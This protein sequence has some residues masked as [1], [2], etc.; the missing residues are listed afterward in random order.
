MPI[1]LREWKQKA[2]KCINEKFTTTGQGTLNHE[3]YLE[4]S[5]FE[6]LF[7]GSVERSLKRLTL[8]RME[9]VNGTKRF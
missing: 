2:T 5:E 3:M 8:T 4:L 6:P 9:Y 1:T 7:D